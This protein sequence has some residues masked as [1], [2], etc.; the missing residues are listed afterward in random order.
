MQQDEPN[1]ARSGRGRPEADLSLAVRAAQGGDEEAFRLLFRDVQPRLLRYL[2][3]IVADD[4]EDVASESWLQIAR[5]LGSFGGDFDAFRGW[6]ATIA[7]HRALD[8]LRSQQRKHSSAVPADLLAD[9]PG[10]EDTAQ[11]ALDAVCSEAAIALI[12]SLPRDQAEAPDV[13]R[14]TDPADPATRA[15]SGLPKSRTEQP[16]SGRALHRPT[17]GPGDRARVPP[18]S[19]VAGAPNLGRILSR[20]S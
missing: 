16:R 9:R 19:P 3:A 17:G 8:H 7:R 12:A 11:R 1:A 4:A 6:A 13:P 2:R 14:P 20:G 15:V 5:D 10:G 18:W